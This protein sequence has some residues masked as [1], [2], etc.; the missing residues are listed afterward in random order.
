MSTITLNLNDKKNVKSVLD[1]IIANPTQEC[2]FR[3]SLEK[4]NIAEEDVSVLQ[5]PSRRSFEEDREDE[6]IFSDP[7]FVDYDGKDDVE[8]AIMDLIKTREN[9]DIN[10]PMGYVVFERI[11]NTWNRTLFRNSKRMIQYLKAIGV[12][13]MDENV[14]ANEENIMDVDNWIGKETRDYNSGFTTSTMLFQTTHQYRKMPHPVAIQFL[15]AKLEDKEVA[16]DSSVIISRKHTST[17]IVIKNGDCSFIIP[18]ENPMSTDADSFQ[19]LMYLHECIVSWLNRIDRKQL[20]VNISDLTFKYKFDD[21]NIWGTNAD[22]FEENGFEIKYSLSTMAEWSIFKS[23]RTPKMRV[24]TMLH[25]FQDYGLNIPGD[26]LEGDINQEFVD[27]S[28]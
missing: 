27:M 13:H 12:R 17:V 20:I 10:F 5:T 25:F 1:H 18:K 8:Y 22:K 28:T 4:T 14:N 15:Q 23:T 6:R 26:M 7:L 21:A 19:R 16:V 11:A 9:C 3:I 2:V 24:E